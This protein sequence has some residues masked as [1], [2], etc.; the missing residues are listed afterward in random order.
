M[1]IK[2][3]HR[4]GVENVD[5]FNNFDFTLKYD[6]VG[7]VFNFGAYFDPNNQKH[8]EMFCVSH[9]H[10]AIVEHNGK[11]LM[12]G[13][14]LN[15]KFNKKSTKQLVNL[16]GYSKPGV[17]EDCNIPLSVLPL[18]YDGLT[19]A[20][21]AKKICDV[22]K[23]KVVID[24]AVNSEMNKSIPKATCEPTTTIKDFLC[25]HATQRNVIITHNVNGDLV[26]TKAKTDMKP[27]FTIDDDNPI[28]STEVELEFNGQEIHSEITV[29]KQAD[30]GN[31]GQYTIKN[32]LCPIVFRP[33]NVVQSSGD[34]ISVKETAENALAAELKNIPLIVTISRW[35]M[36]SDLILPNN[37]L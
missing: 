3:N 9:Y 25:E 14:L 20:Q 19:L 1:N 30:S 11:K 33:K 17:F 27:L 13:Y 26:F 8:A 12:T 4:L 2:I 24:P 23:I 36:N 29:V 6:S 31:A 37:L 16:G 32:P 21:I 28:P 15:E 34:D 18:Q 7:S 35:D 10:E 5:R 22:F